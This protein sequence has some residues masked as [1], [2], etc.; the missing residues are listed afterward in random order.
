MDSPGSLPDDTIPGAMPERWETAV[1]DFAQLVALGLD[2][3]QD[4]ADVIGEVNR[5]RPGVTKAVAAALAGAV[6]GAFVASR[7]PRRRPTTQERA[8]AAA[9]AVRRAAAERASTLEEAAVIAQAA[10]QRLAGRAP[11]VSDIRDRLPRITGPPLKT[12]SPT[13]VIRQPNRATARV[14]GCPHRAVD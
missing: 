7:V 1:E 10:A 12:A 14:V 8:R 9:S 13:C 11:S 3:A 5:T 4:L 2:R 6:A